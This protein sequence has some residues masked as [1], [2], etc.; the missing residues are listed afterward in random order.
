MAGPLF[1]LLLG[2]GISLTKSI[3]TNGNI[4]F[5]EKNEDNRGPLGCLVF[6]LFTYFILIIILCA[7]K[8]VIP[9]GVGVFLLITFVLYLILASFLTFLF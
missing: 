2:M 7:R 4:K 6:L 3:A 1:N 8:F 5:S 9:R